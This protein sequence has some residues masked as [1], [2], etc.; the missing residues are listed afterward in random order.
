MVNLLLDRYHVVVEKRYE[1]RWPKVHRKEAIP[2]HS[3]LDHLLPQYLMIVGFNGD[4]LGRSRN[5][6]EWS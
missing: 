1:I 6:S 4:D 2:N 3:S 5:D